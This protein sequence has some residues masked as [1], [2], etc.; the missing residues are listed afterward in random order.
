M[1]PVFFVGSTELFNPS[2]KFRGR[3][4]NGVGNGNVGGYE[5]EVLLGC[6]KR[7]PA[8]YSFFRGVTV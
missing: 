1:V 8:H 3:S 6:F 2:R 7:E 4:C 5:V